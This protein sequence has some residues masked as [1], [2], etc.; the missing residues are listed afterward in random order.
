MFGTKSGV[1]LRVNGIT[2][3]VIETR[4]SLTSFTFLFSISF[5]LCKQNNC[6]ANGDPSQRDQVHHYCLQEF[7]FAEND[8]VDIDQIPAS[9]GSVLLCVVHQE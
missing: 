5:S 4:I 2:D 9:S 8:A 6:M 7:A 1:Q 3:V